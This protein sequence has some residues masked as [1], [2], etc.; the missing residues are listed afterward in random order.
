MHVYVLKDHLKNCQYEEVPCKNDCGM[1]VQRWALNGHLTQS[2]VRR[3]CS[4]DH[5]AVELEQ[6]QME[7]IQFSL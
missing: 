2:C 6:R 4:C 5:C 1:N 3:M 7:V